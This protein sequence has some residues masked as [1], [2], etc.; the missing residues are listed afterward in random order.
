MAL[1]RRICSMLTGYQ[2]AFRAPSGAEL[3][4]AKR[5]NQSFPVVSRRWTRS[6]LA[7]AGPAMPSQ[8]CSSLSPLCANG[9]C[10]HQYLLAWSRPEGKSCS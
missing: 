6:C 1:M 10:F 2:V 3:R 7:V 8:S 4:S 5:V 9:D